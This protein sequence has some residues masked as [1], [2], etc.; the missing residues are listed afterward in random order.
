M[1]KKYKFKEWAI[2]K[3][4]R[5][6]AAAPEAIAD[7][8]DGFGSA[9]NMTKEQRLNFEIL[10]DEFWEHGG[11]DMAYQEYL[12]RDSWERDHLGTAIRIYKKIN[13]QCAAAYCQ[14]NDNYHRFGRPLEDRLC[15]RIWKTEK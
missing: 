14:F 7:A 3:F 9:S 8:M 11:L 4:W 15:D 13:W 10:Y 2:E 12:E 1:V 5:D 6:R